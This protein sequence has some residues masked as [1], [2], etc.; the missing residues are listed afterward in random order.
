MITGDKLMS[1]LDHNTPTPPTNLNEDKPKSAAWPAAIL[2][3]ILV[4]GAL[5]FA[6]AT[7]E[8]RTANGPAPTTTGQ[9]KPGAR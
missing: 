5:F 3:S 1:D 8:D 9:G 7:P 4:L 6:F 2:G